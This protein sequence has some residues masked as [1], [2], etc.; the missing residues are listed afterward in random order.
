M[1][2]GHAPFELCGTITIPRAGTRPWPGVVLLGFSGRVDKDG[3]IGPNHI[4]KDIAEGLSSRGIVVLRYDKRTL[5]YTEEMRQPYTIKEE[6][7]DDGATAVRFLRSRPEV[8][9]DRI[10][11]AGHSEGSTVAAEVAVEAVPVAG[12]ILLGAGVS[13]AGTF[14]V[15]AWVVR[16]TR[17]LGQTPPERLAELERKADEVDNHQMPPTE[18][19]LGHPASYWYDLEGRNIVADAR[20][21]H[22]PI[23][24]LHGARD[25]QSNDE[26][27]EHWQQGLKG[28]PHVRVT[29]IPALNHMLLTGTGKP[30]DQEYMMPGHVDQRVI[31]AM[32]AFIK[33]PLAN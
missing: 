19:F 32:A 31:D 11:I 8:A 20:K 18:K 33:N 3:T 10:F 9:T 24:I 14:K 1:I 2:V 28:M 17:F 22:I 6:Y 7:L 25:Y 5:V 30:N 21:L 12:L 26:D 27:I 15:G 4:Y 13:K 29:T 16:V 23:L